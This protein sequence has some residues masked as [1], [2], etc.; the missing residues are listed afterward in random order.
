MGFLGGSVVKHLPASTGD[1]GLIP[2]PGKAHLLQ[3][4]LAHAPQL[5]SLCSRAQEP[6]LL[7]PSAA[8]IGA[9]PP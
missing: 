1:T 6:R 2:D 3:G 9:L 8:T 7:R 5:L 4:N